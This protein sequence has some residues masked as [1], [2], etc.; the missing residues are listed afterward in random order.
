VLFN[1]VVDACE[2]MYLFKEPK[3][4]TLRTNFTDDHVS[5]EVENNGGCITSVEHMLEPAGMNRGEQTWP[6]RS[7]VPSSWRKGARS[8]LFDKKEE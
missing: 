6:W 7:A 8:K 2:A 1:L 3:K 4:L 5:L